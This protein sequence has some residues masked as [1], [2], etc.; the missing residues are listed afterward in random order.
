MTEQMDKKKK[1]KTMTEHRMWTY[2]GMINWNVSNIHRPLINP[3][4][5]HNIAYIFW[6][7]HFQIVWKY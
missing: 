3:P 1:K 2:V 5:P 7:L 4:P 6:V